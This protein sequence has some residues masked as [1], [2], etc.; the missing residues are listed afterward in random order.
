[1]SAKMLK[2][3]CNRSAMATL[4][5]RPDRALQFRPA[6][7]TDACRAVRS[8]KRLGDVLASADESNINRWCGRHAKIAPCI[9]TPERVGPCR[10]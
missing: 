9:A 4:W 8:A 1:M 2:E 10:V 3:A 5:F 6:R 7:T